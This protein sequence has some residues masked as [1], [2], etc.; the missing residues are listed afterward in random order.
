[1]RSPC[2]A[3]SAPRRTSSS[4]IRPT[5]RFAE[6]APA[7]FPKLSAALLA[8]GWGGL[9]VGFEMPGEV[10]LEPP[11]WACLKR[12]GRGARQPSVAFLSLSA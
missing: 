10:K 12:L 3:A 2:R 6:V 7:L 9:V 8:P 5:R 1:M 4:S 11:G